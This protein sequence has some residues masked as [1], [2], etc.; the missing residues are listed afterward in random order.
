MSAAHS[1]EPSNKKSSAV[2]GNALIIF[3][4]RLAIL[5]IQRRIRGR[6]LKKKK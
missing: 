5:C 4:N 3:N 1:H 2:Y 6:V